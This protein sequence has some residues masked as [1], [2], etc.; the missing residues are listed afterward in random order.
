MEVITQ[1]KLIFG[2]DSWLGNIGRMILSEILL[3]GNDDAIS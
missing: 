2:I 1:T 3:F